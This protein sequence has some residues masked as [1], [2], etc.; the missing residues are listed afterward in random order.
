[1]NGLKEKTSVKKSSSELKFALN[2]SFNANNF[3]LPF[4]VK[5]KESGKQKK[6][7]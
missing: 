2:G 3:G 6:G 1:M 7:K 4:P 5:E